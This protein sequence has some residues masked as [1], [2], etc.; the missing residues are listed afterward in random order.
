[1]RFISEFSAERELKLSGSDG[2]A[3]F[4]AL[5]LEATEDEVVAE[6]EVVLEDSGAVE[7]VPRMVRVEVASTSTYAVVVIMYETPR[8]TA[9]RRTRMESCIL[10]QEASQKLDIQNR[11][12]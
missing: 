4:V 11:E 7:V 3:V 5:L 10:R 6:A 1:M 12:E 9:P 8:C 2:S